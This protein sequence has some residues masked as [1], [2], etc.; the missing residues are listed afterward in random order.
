MKIGIDGEE[1]WR[2]TN[3][4]GEAN[5]RERELGNLSEFLRS[6]SDLPCYGLVISTKYYIEVM[7][8]SEEDTKRMNDFRE[9][10]DAT[11]TLIHKTTT[12]RFFYSKNRHYLC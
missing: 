4:Y 5:K 12:I 1:Q 8:G 3:I 9:V 6:E 7:L 10:V 11:G 2:L